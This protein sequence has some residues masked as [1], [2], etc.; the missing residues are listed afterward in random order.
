MTRHLKAHE[1]LVLLRTFSK[2]WALAGIRLGYLLASCAVVDELCKVRQPYSVDA[3]SALAGRAVLDAATEIGDRVTASV[4]ERARLATA[5]EEMPG[6]EVFSSQA[7]FILFRADGAHS[8]WRRLYDEDGILLRDFSAARG[9]TDC[10]RVSVGTPQEND[11][12]LAALRRVTAT[13]P[14]APLT[15]TATTPATPAPPVPTGDSTGGTS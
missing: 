12:F 2:A 13:A 6:V 9:L 15:A 7:N 1:N 8:I 11:E 3:F 14:A 10:L 4:A 5:L